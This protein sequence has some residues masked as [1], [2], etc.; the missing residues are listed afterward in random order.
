MADCWVMWARGRSWRRCRR[1]QRRVVTLMAL[2]AAVGVV[3]GFALPRVS[4]SIGE[5]VGLTLSYGAAF[6]AMQRIFVD[7]G[8]GDQGYDRDSFDYRG[9]D[10]DGDGCDVRDE[11]LA[12]D[13]SGVRFDPSDGCTVRSGVL[14]DPYTSERIEFVRGPRTS[15]AVQIDH[16]VAL[17]N[18]WRS[19][20][21]RWD[22]TMRRRFGND[23]RNLLAVD[24][25]ANQDKGSASAAY[26]LPENT[27]F[28]CEYVARQVAVKLV[29]GLSVTSREKQAMSRV[30]RTCPGQTLPIDVSGTVDATVSRTDV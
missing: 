8:F 3:V 10:D 2:S 5:S 12:R 1:I 24:G 14:D 27:G 19:G 26:W 13:M 7:D 29:Y 9:T 23:A 18:A 15:S 25:G 16:V 6:E 17:E 21:S 22:S 30:L 4:P 28:R 20:A 11:V